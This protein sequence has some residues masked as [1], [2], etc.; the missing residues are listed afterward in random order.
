MKQLA[1]F[2][3]II[4]GTLVNAQTYNL[5]ITITNIKNIKG[6]IILSLYNSE[7]T[8]PRKNE[9]FKTAS[10]PVNGNK[11]KY[12]FIG[13]PSGEYAVALFH[14]RN[15][16]GICN[17]NFIGKPKESYGFSRNYKPKFSAPD[18]KDCKILLNRN[19]QITIELII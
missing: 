8:F 7:K 19:M 18:F 10:I 11:E 14:D 15:S 1:L 5:E 17:R 9:E 4:V 16:D 3:F 2:I 13:L 6:N 12:T